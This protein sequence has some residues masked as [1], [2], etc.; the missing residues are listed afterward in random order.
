MAINREKIKELVEIFYQPV[1]KTF[2]INSL[3]G[4]TLVKPDS[5]FVSLGMTTSMKGI[6][7]MRDII[8]SSG[9]YEAEIVEISS[10][11]ILG[12]FINKVTK[13]SPSQ[14]EVTELPEGV[15]DRDKALEEVENLREMLS[16]DQDISILNKVAPKVNQL[17]KMINKFDQQGLW[18]EQYILKPEDESGCEYKVFLKHVNY[19][20]DPN[21]GLEYRIGILVREK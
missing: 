11:K 1:F 6:E 21:T 5:V 13:K 4:I 14:Y 15:M 16:V 8:E 9:G 3:D 12:Q 10:R 20:Q 7:G 17:Q 2:Y 19:R 18:E